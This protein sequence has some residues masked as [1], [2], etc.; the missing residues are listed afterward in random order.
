MFQRGI[1]KDAVPAMVESGVTIE[2]KPDDPPYPSRLVLGWLHGCPLHV[3][4]AEDS[5][6][7]QNI[8]VTV[9]EPDPALWHP[10]IRRRRKR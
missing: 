7:N 10:N 4:V 9:Y 1:T 6:A 8:V 5:A 3:V 2:T